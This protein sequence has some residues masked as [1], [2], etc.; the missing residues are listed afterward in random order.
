MTLQ[1]QI[2]TLQAEILTLK[3][4]SPYNPLIKAKILQLEELIYARQSTEQ[5]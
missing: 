2:K 4:E 3:L 1:E 5:A